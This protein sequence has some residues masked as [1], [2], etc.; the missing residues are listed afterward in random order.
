MS[1]GRA[2]R[3][4]ESRVPHTSRSLRCVGSCRLFSWRITDICAMHSC[5]GKQVGR[6]VA[7]GLLD[8]I[9]HFLPVG[10]RENVCRRFW[11]W[12][13]IRPVFSATQQNKRGT[14]TSVGQLQPATGFGPVRLLAQ[15]LIY[16]LYGSNEVR[17]CSGMKDVNRHRG[18]GRRRLVCRSEAHVR[19]IDIETIAATPNI[20]RQICG[21]IGGIR[22]PHACFPVVEVFPGVAARRSDVRTGIVAGLD[23]EGVP[24]PR[25]FLGAMELH[26]LYSSGFILLTH[27]GLG[28][29]EVNTTNIVG[30]LGVDLLRA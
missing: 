10:F 16:F 23:G 24:C 29:G 19:T 2:S 1:R 7:N 18:H 4:S 14:L 25:V 20:W 9:G 22:L 6:T 8:L 30:I 5:F 12:S 26:M 21:S 17:S 28:R 11:Q 27:T 3:S 13:E 15:R